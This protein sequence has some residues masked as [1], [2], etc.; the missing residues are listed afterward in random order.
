MV[1][2]SAVGPV[3]GVGVTGVV[4]VLPNKPLPPDKLAPGAVPVMPA[5]AADASAANCGVDPCVVVEAPSV[6]FEGI[7]VVCAGTVGAVA[8]DRAVSNCRPMKMNQ[9]TYASCCALN[10]K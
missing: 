3:A 9:P 6:D 1:E 10:C 2:V 5:E 4:G 8:V 7:P